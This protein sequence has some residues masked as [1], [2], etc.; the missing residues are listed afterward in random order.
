MAHAPVSPAAIA[1]H[2]A[3]RC[4]NMRQAIMQ[5]LEAENDGKPQAQ[6]YAQVFG[7]ALQARVIHHVAGLVREARQK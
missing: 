3:L 1:R 2:A 4:D 5:A 6:Q 7:E